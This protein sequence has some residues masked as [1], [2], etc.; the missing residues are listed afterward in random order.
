[1]ASRSFRIFATKEDLSAIFSEFQSNMKVHYFECGR[2]NKLTEAQDI[3]K[4]EFFGVNI[5][6]KHLG[7]QW[8]VCLEHVIPQKRKMICYK[9]KVSFL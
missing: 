1:M 5:H 9:M 2:S 8:L 6:G 7:N 3:T 4:E